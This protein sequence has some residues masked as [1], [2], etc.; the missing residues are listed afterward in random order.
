MKSDLEKIHHIHPRFNR[1]FSPLLWLAGALVTGLLLLLPYHGRLAVALLINVFFNRPMVY[2]NYAARWI[3]RPLHHLNLAL[4][5]GFLFGLFA[6]VYGLFNRRRT[7]V[8]WSPPAIPN[9]DASGKE[10]QS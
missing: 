6:V 3:A 1:L 10:F 8:R 7:S 4:F 2:L 9:T 5:Y